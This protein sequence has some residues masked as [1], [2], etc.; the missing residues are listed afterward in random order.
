MIEYS[1]SSSPH[2]SCQSPN[3]L[4]KEV[5]YASRVISIDPRAEFARECAVDRCAKESNL[6]EYRACFYSTREFYADGVHPNVWGADVLART[7]LKALD[8][9]NWI[10]IYDLTRGSRHYYG[11]RRLCVHLYGG[12]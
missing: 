12:F 6:S 4:R 10:P 8:E 9:E 5:V 1:G 2:A 11:R 3:R 7:V